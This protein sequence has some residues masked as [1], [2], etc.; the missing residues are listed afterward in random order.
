MKRFAAI[1]L[2]LLLL[3]KTA[4]AED[5]NDAY[6]IGQLSGYFKD[7]YESIN[8]DKMPP[9]E[10]KLIFDIKHLLEQYGFAEESLTADGIEGLQDKINQLL[11]GN[12]KE[13]VLFT[14]PDSDIVNCWL[15]DLVEEKRETRNIWGEKID[16]MV[17]VIDNLEIRDFAY[18]L[19]KGREALDVGTRGF[20]ICYNLE[21]Y[22]MRA[23]SVWD[24]FRDRK[25][26][27][28][29]KRY[30]P[31]KSNRLRKWLYHKTW[32]TLYSDCIKDNKHLEEAKTEFI[33]RAVIILRENSLFH[34]IGHIFADRYLKLNDDAEE[35]MIA[36]LGELRYGPLPYESLETIIAASYKSSMVSYNLAGRQIIAEFL[37]FIRNEQKNSN[38]DYE[39]INIHGRNQIEKINNLYKLSEAE[40]R[41]ISEYI[42][43]QKRN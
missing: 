5:I 34:E 42:Y 14:L 28:K 26:K 18:V 7:Y 33:D 4:L 41:A 17:K 23:N 1:F 16:F 30:D 13:V 24:F 2:P 6:L 36:F 27:L 19:T 8:Q 10:G 32:H 29:N 38:P 37:S 39:D 31:S 40:I 21:A 3:A 25:D 12:N 11:K 20:I 22:K 43:E 9:Y 15:G 35:E